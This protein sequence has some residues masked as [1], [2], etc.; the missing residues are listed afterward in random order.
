MLEVCAIGQ[1]ADQTIQVPG[2]IT[3]APIATQGVATGGAVGFDDNA[4]VVAVRG[5]VL[6]MFGS[7]V[8]ILMMLVR[9]S[10]GC[11]IPTADHRGVSS[12]FGNKAGKYQQGHKHANDESRKVAVVLSC[13]AGWPQNML[14]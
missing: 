2:K 9:V 6:L 7:R 3:P 11:L 12:A 8:R 5:G 14:R 1:V 13:S 4:D 10:G